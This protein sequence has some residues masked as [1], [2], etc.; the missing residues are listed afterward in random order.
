MSIYHYIF[1]AY[2]NTYN[3]LIQKILMKILLAINIEKSC[4]LYHGLAKKDTADVP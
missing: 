1:C 2:T 3:L 4:D